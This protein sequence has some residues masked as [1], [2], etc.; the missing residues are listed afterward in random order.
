MESVDTMSLPI[1]TNIT[2]PISS[3]NTIMIYPVKDSYN[4][5]EIVSLF[6]QFTQKVSA[7]NTAFSGLPKLAVRFLIEKGI[8]EN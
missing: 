2:I 6:S 1:A 3:D 8:L 4:N 7:E 5:E